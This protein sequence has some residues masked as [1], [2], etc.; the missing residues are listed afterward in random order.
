MIVIVVSHH[1]DWN[2]DDTWPGGT[3][4]IERPI[5]K[6]EELFQT[7]FTLYNRQN[8]EGARQSVEE[9]YNLIRLRLADSL[10]GDTWQLR[11]INLQI[12]KEF[13]IACLSIIHRISN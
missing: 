6:L 1:Q 4:E 10:E 7:A 2:E 13:E 11:F 9:A 12:K 5:Q 3:N 8:F